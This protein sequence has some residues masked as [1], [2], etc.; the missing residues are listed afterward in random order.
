MLVTMSKIRKTITMAALSLTVAVACVACGSSSPKSTKKH[1]PKS[2]SLQAKT[3]QQVP[4]FS[5]T[6]LTPAH[7]TALNAEFKAAFPYMPVPSTMH[8]SAHPRGISDSAQLPKGCEA[9]RAATGYRIASVKKGGKAVLLLVQ[10]APQA[11]VVYSVVVNYCP[12]MAGVQDLMRSFK[13]GMRPSKHPGQWFASGQVPPGASTYVE[14]GSYA[15]TQAK[16]FGWGANVHLPA[17]EVAE[18]VA[19]Q[20]GHYIFGVW[21]MAPS[22]A[23]IHQF[24]ASFKVI[25]V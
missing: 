22:Q 7:I 19:V 13:I 3:E 17:S 4:A 15:L 16:S 10:T 21:A 9:G 2:T 1:V 12:A 23:L 5:K 20:D 6:A 25:K 14:T 8:M 11:E 24:L 18:N